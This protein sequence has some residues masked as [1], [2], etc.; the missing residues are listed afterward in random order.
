MTVWG[1]S[2]AASQTLNIL[3]RHLLTLSSR[4]Q[5]FPSG[6]IHR[7]FIASQELSHTDATSE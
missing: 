6:L 2:P 7:N 5:N 1:G 4:A 3:P